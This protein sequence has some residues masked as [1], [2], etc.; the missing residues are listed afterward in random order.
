MKIARATDDDMQRMLAFFA[1]L[2]DALRD[3]RYGGLVDDENIGA[4]VR[5]HWGKAGPGVGASWCRVLYGMDTLL[6]NCTD[7][8]ASTLEWRPDVREW[9][10]SQEEVDREDKLPDG[11]TA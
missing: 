1:E 4:L 3:A 11:R 6:R 7:P 10:E 8:E 9:L 2:D 5:K